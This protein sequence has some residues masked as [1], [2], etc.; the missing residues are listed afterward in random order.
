MKPIRTHIPLL[1]DIAVM[2]IAS[3]FL[4]FNVVAQGRNPFEKPKTV[5]CAELLKKQQNMVEAW[6]FRG[7]VTQNNHFAALIFDVKNNIWHTL[8]PNQFLLPTYWFVKN[9]TFDTLTLAF[10][11]RDVCDVLI[12]KQVILP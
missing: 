5:L 11:S 9:I 12:E 8:T 10:M 3:I 6:Q 1:G 2:L 7:T 4:A